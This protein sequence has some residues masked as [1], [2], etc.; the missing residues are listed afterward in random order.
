[1]FLSKSEEE[2]GSKKKL[3]KYLIEKWCRIIFNKSTRFNDLRNTD[4][5]HIPVMKKAVNKPAIMEYVEADL[6]FN[7]A[8]EEKLSSRSSCSSQRALR[9]EPTPSVYVVNPKSN[10]NPEIAKAYRRQQ[11]LGDTRESIAKRLKQL[12]AS[13]KKPLQAEKP[14]A[15]GRR[16]L[17]SA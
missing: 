8:K 13:K 3:A 15:E 5:I 7:V 12:K 16:M 11:V 2:I 4:D 6:D 1:M 17:P 9:P 10:Y 14:S